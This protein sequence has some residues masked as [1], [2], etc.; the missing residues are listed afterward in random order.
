MGVLVPDPGNDRPKPQRHVD[1]SLLLIPGDPGS[2]LDVQNGAHR[3]CAKRPTIRP[4]SAGTA[5][6]WS[7]PRR[8]SSPTRRYLGM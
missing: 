6:F 3:P 4:R 1:T 7:I 8:C 5:G 2:F